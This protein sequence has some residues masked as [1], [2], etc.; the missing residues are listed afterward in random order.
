M[1][2]QRKTNFYI[3]TLLLTIYL[4]GFKPLISQEIKKNQT[5]NLTTIR[6]FPD[7]NKD[8]SY[9]AYPSQM[10]TDDDW[11]IYICD[12]MGNTIHKFDKKGVFI[13]DIGREG[14][15]P[16]E[17]IR[18][19]SICYGDNKIFA[20]DVSN[21][22]LQTFD[23]SGIYL[24]SFRFINSPYNILYSKENIYAVIITRLENRKNL[25][26]VFNSNGR[27]IN[28]FGEY[29]TL[30]PKL[31][32]NASKAK[33]CLYNKEI[34]LLFRYYP[35]MRVYHINGKLEKEIKFD[36]ID[37]RKL[38]PQNYHWS[39]FQGKLDNK[40][41]REYPFRFLYNG[42]VVNENGIFLGL[43]HDDIIIDQYNFFGKFM[44]RFTKHHKAE[45]YYM[46]DFLV[47][48]QQNNHFKFYVLNYKKNGGGVPVI[49]IFE[50]R[51]AN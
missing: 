43:Y 12:H 31:T 51:V 25:I 5:F 21:M 46:F 44:R 13:K 9:I 47:N 4:F 40:Q 6:S 23:K 27:K 38:T 28:E 8:T 30:A 10:I 45:P 19:Y 22:R 39:K 14:Q 17:L 41:A 24:S 3:V 34:Y 16:G 20:T 50:S 1:H 26:S 18:P 32:H 7:E 48:C 29:L 49:D 33:M 2:L 15:G 37:Y 35:I 42:F 36:E 11:N